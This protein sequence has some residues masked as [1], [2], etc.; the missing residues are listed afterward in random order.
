MRHMRS[1]LHPQSF[2]FA[3]AGGGVAAAPGA[4]P[5]AAVAA[6]GLPP[7]GGGCHATPPPVVGF[8]FPEAATEAEGAAAAESTVGA[9]A[10]AVASGGAPAE[11]ALPADALAAVAAVP[12][13][14]N[15]APMTNARINARATPATAPMIFGSLLLRGASPRGASSAPSGAPNAGIEPKGAEKT[16][17]SAMIAGRME[18]VFAASALRSMSPE[19]SR[20]VVAA[21]AAGARS[22]AVFVRTASEKRTEFSLRSPVNLFGS[23]AAAIAP[24]WMSGALVCTPWMSCEPWT[25][26]ALRPVANRSRPRPSRFTAA[27]FGSTRAG[28]GLAVLPRL[29]AAGEPYGAEAFAVKARVGSSGSP[30][31][32]EIRGNPCPDGGVKRAHVRRVAC[33]RVRA[34]GVARVLVKRAEDRLDLAEWLPIAHPLGPNERVGRNGRRMVRRDDLRQGH[35]PLVVLGHVDVPLAATLGSGTR[36]GRRLRPGGGSVRY[37]AAVEPSTTMVAPHLRHRIL[38]IFP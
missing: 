17:P 35:R 28:S 19:S 33:G 10:D 26:L 3:G 38:T 7:P 5:A 34:R 6:A 18:S 30:W 2:F 27:R 9:E 31:C 25:S 1:P 37:A 32:G 11:G 23:S 14:A 15:L 20:V 13:P 16:E 21:S 22:S 8:G 4:A 12:G 29:A 36:G 24:G